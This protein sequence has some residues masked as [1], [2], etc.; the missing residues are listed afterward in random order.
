MNSGE[1]ESIVRKIGELWP[2]F[3]L[4]APEVL[5]LIDRIKR[6]NNI[7]YA[8]ACF[9]LQAMRM[10]EILQPPK[11]DL[12]M[13]VRHELDAL[14]RELSRELRRSPDQ[15]SPV[16]ELPYTQ[17]PVK[18]MMLCRIKNGGDAR[19]GVC[20]WDY[21]VG[22]ARQCWA[23]GQHVRSAMHIEELLSDMSALGYSHDAVCR[24]LSSDG[25]DI[26]YLLSEIDKA[27]ALR[28][29]SRIKWDARREAKRSKREKSK[30]AD[31]F[32]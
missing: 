8:G 5:L 32:P 21:H 16:T 6:M 12:V 23:D 17:A 24:K 3:A 1:A 2:R 22:L 7:D 30:S 11:M 26:D 10:G 9:R 31:E 14:N 28:A 27:K 29:E 4:G 18:H 25:A 15:A 20:A 19:P 13:W